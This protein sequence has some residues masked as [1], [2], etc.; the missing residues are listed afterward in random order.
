MPV[1]SGKADSNMDQRIG[2]SVV[3]H[4]LCAFLCFQSSVMSTSEIRGEIQ[5]IIIIFINASRTEAK[6]PSV[7]VCQSRPSPVESPPSLT[8]I[9]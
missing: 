5:I 8:N 9:E 1:F 6:I 3:S 7:L 2:L 4:F